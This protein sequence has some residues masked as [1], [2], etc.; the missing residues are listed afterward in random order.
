MLTA[1]NSHFR[2]VFRYFLFNLKCS[3]QYR[4]SFILQVV[5]MM[6]NN[7]SFL[8]FWWLIYRNVS[9]INGYTFGDTMILWGLASSSYGFCYIFVG[10]VSSLSNII[11]NGSLDS[12]LVQ[13]KD[14]VINTCSSRMIISAW[15]DLT[16]GYILLFVS[17]RFSLTGIAL[18]TLFV[19]TGG[20]IYF[21]TVLAVNSLTLYLGNIESTKNIVEAFFITF[22]TYPEGLFGKYLRLLFYTILP[23]GFMVYMP[24]YIMSNFNFI[25]L[26]IIC[27]AS[28]TALIL[29]YSLFYFGLKR[30]E[31]GNLMEGKI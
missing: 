5:S 17:G 13:P 24:V 9:S 3:L 11:V 14:V 8:F 6:I 10:N 1:V 18:F 25:K 16:F 19:I 2:L 29:S 26:I 7:S 15:G 21:S 28:L 4:F 22:A 27:T 20:V 23:V 31:S 30:Y 12:Y